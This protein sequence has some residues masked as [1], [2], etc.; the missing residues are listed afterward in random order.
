MIA[1]QRSVPVVLAVGMMLVTPAVAG[2]RVAA[3][4]QN[5]AAQLSETYADIAARLERSVVSIDVTERVRSVRRFRDGEREREIEGV[6]SG[7][8][9][10]A[11]GHILTNAHVVEGA[12]EIVVR[13]SD[14][15]ELE[16]A[17]VGV[18]DE[19]DLA[20]LD[21]GAVAGLQPVA[22]GDSDLIRPGHLVLAMGSPFGFTNSVSAGIVSAEGRDIPGGEAFQRFIQT[23][24]AIHPGNS[25][26][27]LVNMA[28]EVIGVNTALV[29]S[30]R[31]ASG[32]GFALPS[33]TARDV[34]EQLRANGRVVRGSIGITFSSDPVE[35]GGVAVT[36]ILRSGPA[37]A[38]GI[39][40]GDFI[41]EFAGQPTPDGESLLEIVAA[42]PV[43][44]RVPVRVSR[45]GTVLDLEVMIADRD[46]LYPVGRVER[47][48]FR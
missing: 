34:F 11:G 3:T 13:L 33:S 5:F 46:A 31:L 15:T 30:P 38:A 48:R 17:V 21:V 8:V 25:G 36:G 1:M 35:A 6:G 43:G 4:S 47:S 20:L 9:V 2:M 18:D 40:P 32:V 10:D 37:G 26:G 16:A 19:T 45:G 24:A 14:D 29:S 27:P 42:Q 39:E 41:V 7:F 28:G 12:T 44:T 23:D 22:F